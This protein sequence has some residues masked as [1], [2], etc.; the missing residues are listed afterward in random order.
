MFVFNELDSILFKA[1]NA[2]ELI[3]GQSPLSR[4]NQS[5]IC[6][7]DHL[8]TPERIAQASLIRA[9]LEKELNHQDYRCLKLNYQ[10]TH[11]VESALIVADPLINSVLTEAKIPQAYCNRIFAGLCCLSAAWD[12]NLFRDRRYGPAKR[13]CSPM[14]ASRRKKRIGDV[15]GTWRQRAVAAAARVLGCY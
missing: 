7:T 13:Y 11:D 1:F 8:T 2:T 15:M 12:R 9:R 4:F 14:L 10:R 3:Q 5:E 6:L